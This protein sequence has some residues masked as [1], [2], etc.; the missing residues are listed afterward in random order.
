MYQIVIKSTNFG[1]ALFYI[2]NSKKSESADVQIKASIMYH[3]S[4]N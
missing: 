2:K 3:I 1:H 4:L